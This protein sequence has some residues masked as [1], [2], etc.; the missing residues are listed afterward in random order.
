MNSVFLHR[1]DLSASIDKSAEI[2]TYASGV[3]Q[4]NIK[5]VLKVTYALADA[6]IPH[7]FGV[8][9]GKKDS[10]SAKVR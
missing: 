1:N 3:G 2:D 8:G 5:I 6:T 10:D 4:P 7:G 9:V